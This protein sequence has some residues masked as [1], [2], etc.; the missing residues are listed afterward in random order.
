MS[1]NKELIWPGIMLI[2]S[3]TNVVGASVAIAKGDG[4]DSLAFKT[5][6]FTSCVYSTGHLFKLIQIKYE[7]W[8]ER[9]DA[10]RVVPL[11]AIVINR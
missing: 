2:A 8:R 4:D 1:R 7:S 11:E 3:L 10:R 9:E 5:G 6:L